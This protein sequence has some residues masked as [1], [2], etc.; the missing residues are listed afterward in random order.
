M[1]HT[2]RCV[3]DKTELEHSLVRDAIQWS[4][5]SRFAGRLVGLALS[6]ETL[7]KVSQRVNKE[8]H[9]TIHLAGSVKG[10]TAYW[11]SRVAVRKSIYFEPG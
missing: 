3:E 9:D 2:S 1:N 7:V 10:R 5:R 8:R 11:S 6:I 4:C